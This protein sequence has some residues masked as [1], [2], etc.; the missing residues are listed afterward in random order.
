[1]LL[2]DGCTSTGQ[3]RPDRDALAAEEGDKLER[4]FDEYLEAQFRVSPTL[5][6]S[7]GD[8]RFDAELDDLSPAGLARRDECSYKFLAR[9][10]HAVDRAKLSPEDQADFD[11]LQNELAGS[12]FTLRQLRPFEKDPL[13]YSSLI[14]DSV[15]T[16]LKR[17]FAPL[18]SRV[19]S[20]IG[21]MKQLPRLVEQ[22]KTNLRAPPK[23]H[24]QVAI[25]RNKG[26]I[27]FYDGEIAEFVK[28]S[29]LEAQVLA[30]GKRIA[31]TLRSYQSWLETDLLS[32]ATGDWR[33]GRALWEQKLQ[34]SLD[35]SL[36]AKEIWKRAVSE[37]ERVREQMLEVALS[38][39]PKYFPGSA[40][41]SG[42]D[43]VTATVRAV[44]DKVSQEHSTRES[45]VRDARETVE[46][47]RAFLRPGQ[48]VALPEP[49]RCNVI[50][51]PEFQ[52]GVSV[53]YLDPA[54]PLEP[55]G[56]SFYAIEPLPSSFGD[57]EAESRLREYNTHMLKVLSIHEGYPGHYVQLEYSNRFPS[58]I[59][60]V[61]SN[62][63]MVEGWAVYTE[64][65][66]VANG[67]GGGDPRLRLNQLK[68]YL[69]AVTNALLDQGLHCGEM[70]EDQAIAKMIGGAF[71][72]RN[73]ATGKL[74]RA[75][76]TATQLSTYFVGFQEIFSLY[77]DMR[78]RESSAFSLKRF[79][80]RFL[81]H[82]SPPVRVIRRAMLGER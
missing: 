8:H 18:D 50:E 10:P 27:A 21:R 76:V 34:Y 61:L 11:I 65:M 16:L 45:L 20:A 72:E 56:K 79:H 69:R 30:E 47:L 24:T 62:G 70:G 67:Y 66:M 39:W 38:L 41:P 73:E 15:Y 80:E 2:V 35:S 7:L 48:L 51:M 78:G 59:R 46:D 68:F 14:S 31:E 6:T 9:L 3:R 26:A 60:K 49:D 42:P 57:E 17:D 43:A 32:R 71:Q 75:Q 13:V 58:K 52:A 28:G 82:G 77:A 29:S 54:P 63:P 36:S 55:D 81:S 12:V 23:P 25:R 33:L 74:V 37:F 19:A 40:P 22:A 1:M 53:A 4:Y 5:A 64:Q 44:L